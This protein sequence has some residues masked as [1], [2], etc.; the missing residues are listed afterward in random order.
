ML[1]RQATLKTEVQEIIAYFFPLIKRAPHSTTVK[2]VFKALKKMQL[3]AKT[4]HFKE[5]QAWSPTYLYS[6]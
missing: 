5:C 3:I 6:C 2:H 1:L 4:I